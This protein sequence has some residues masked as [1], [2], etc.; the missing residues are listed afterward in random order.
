MGKSNLKGK[1]KVSVKG[2]KIK[3]KRVREEY[4]LFV[5]REGKHIIFKVRR[6]K[7]GFRTGYST[8]CWEG[9]FKTVFLF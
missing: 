1:V 5:A 4:I 2:A 6:E 8:L 3:A 7:D 9:C